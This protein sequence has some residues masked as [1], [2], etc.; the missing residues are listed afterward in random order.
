MQIIDCQNESTLLSDVEIAQTFWK[1]FRGLMLR[2]HFPPSYGI[3]IQPCSSLHTMWMRVSIDI[4]FLDADGTVL[5]VHR[6][7]KPWKFI[8]PKQRCQSVLE[9]PEGLDT[10]QPGMRIRAA[11]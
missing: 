1:R 6:Q 2:K 4:F 8:I 3:W 5:E 9:V 11:D 7:V 10:L